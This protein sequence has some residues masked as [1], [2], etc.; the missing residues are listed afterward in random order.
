MPL[1]LTVNIT[2]NPILNHITC[3]LEILHPTSMPFEKDMEQPGDWNGT[4]GLVYWS[5]GNFAKRPKE[6]RSCDRPFV[7]TSRHTW[8][9]TYKR[10]LK[11]VLS[12]FLKKI[13]CPIGRRVLY[14]KFPL[15]TL[16]LKKNHSLDFNDFSHR[17]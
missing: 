17:C 7:R 4:T 11:N 16:Y 5:L 2:P 15:L 10:K 13:F 1:I 12:R 8:R 14:P 9:S 6:S 3:Y